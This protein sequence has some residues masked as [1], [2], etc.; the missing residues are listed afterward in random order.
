MTELNEISEVGCYDLLKKSLK[1]G[2]KKFKIEKIEQND[3][4]ETI[5]EDHI[6]EIHPANLNI[7]PYSLHFANENPYNLDQTVALVESKEFIVNTFK[8]PVLNHVAEYSLDVDLKELKQSNVEV[9]NLTN[10]HVFIF[11]IVR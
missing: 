1:K 10:L 3:V 9:H 4:T 5:P 2:N 6:K 8:C 7:D 11:N